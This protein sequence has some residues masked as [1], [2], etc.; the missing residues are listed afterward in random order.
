MVHF[1]YRDVRMCHRLGDSIL[2]ESSGPTFCNACG[3]PNGSNARF[4]SECGVALALSAEASIR[5]VRSSGRTDAPKDAKS[6]C[7]QGCVSAV[8]LFAVLAGVTGVVSQC[9]GHDAN[10][11]SSAPVSD[12]TPDATDA[13]TAKPNG[14]A[15]RLAAHDWWN[16]EILAL[17]IA[18]ETITVAKQSVARGDI[19]TASSLFKEGQKYAD[20]AR[21]GAMNPPDGWSDVGQDMSSAAASF[22]SSLQKGRDFMDS[23]KPSEAAAAIE[24]NGEGR[25]YLESATHKAR[26]KYIEMG[27]KW[28]D[29]DD[30]EKTAGTVDALV[31]A[32]SR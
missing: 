18:N 23:Q 15:D 4:C 8:V 16:Q 5:T 28:S 31:K 7:A 9:S 19:V 26:V 13:P 2:S 6:G 32:I 21:E 1:A 17:S 22:S 27:G 25:T 12:A 14:H 29:L 10:T 3:A 30:L 11:G 24:S 20:K